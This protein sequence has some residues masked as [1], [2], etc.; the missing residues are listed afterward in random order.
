LS[1]KLIEDGKTNL[2]L[3]II[4]PRQSESAEFDRAE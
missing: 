3:S 2:Y 1:I 4:C